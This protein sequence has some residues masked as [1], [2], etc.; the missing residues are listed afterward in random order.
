MEGWG[1]VEQDGSVPVDLRVDLI[2]SD[3]TPFVI[4]LISSVL[5]GWAVWVGWG[6]MGQVGWCSSSDPHH[7]GNHRMISFT[8][9]TITVVYCR[10][11]S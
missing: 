10:P 3:V 1:G 9:L 6:R 8:T 2:K 5:M 11:R 7:F 4:W